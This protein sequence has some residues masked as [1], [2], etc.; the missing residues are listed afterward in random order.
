MTGSIMLGLITALPGLAASVTAASPETFFSC[1]HKEDLPG[2]IKAWDEAVQGEKE[3]DQI[4][5]IMRRQLIHLS[6]VLLGFHSGAGR[7]RSAL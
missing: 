4:F 5:R 7:R 6:V 2:L 1:V 3:Y